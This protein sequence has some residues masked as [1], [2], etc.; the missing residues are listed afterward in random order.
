M[1][2]LRKDAEA[3]EEAMSRVAGRC[4]IWQDRII[5]AIC[6]AVWHLLQAELRRNG[7]TG[8]TARKGK[9]K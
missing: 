4:D 3:M 7:G 5:Y 1:D 2:E 6:R 8:A 9:F